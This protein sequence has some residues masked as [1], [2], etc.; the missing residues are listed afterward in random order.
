MNIYDLI[1][2]NKSAMEILG[3]SQEDDLK[4]KIKFVIQFN[5]RSDNADGPETL[6]DQLE[7]QDF[8]KVKEEARKRLAVISPETLEF[9]RDE[10]NEYLDEG[11]TPYVDPYTLVPISF[12]RWEDESCE[13]IPYVK[14]HTWFPLVDIPLFT[15]EFLGECMDIWIRIKLIN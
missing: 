5:N 8:D 14:I 6:E 9:M 10:I 4:D 7:F 1:K 12:T 11:L 2:D 15:S 13:Y 3:L